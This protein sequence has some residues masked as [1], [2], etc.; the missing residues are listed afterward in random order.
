[1]L[2]DNYQ[3]NMNEIERI[4]NDK[5]KITRWLGRQGKSG[6]QSK[7]NTFF[8]QPHR[9]KRMASENVNIFRETWTFSHFWCTQKP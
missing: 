6:E 3:I 1:M 4:W 2:S 9:V 8:K 5:K 7:R